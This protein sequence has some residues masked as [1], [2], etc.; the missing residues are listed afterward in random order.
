MTTPIPLVASLLS[1]GVAACA[2]SPAQPGA[3]AP[4]PAPGTAL[5]SEWAPLRP[6]IGA[7]SGTGGDAAHPSRGG[8]TMAPD[9]GGTLLVRR[10][11]NDTATAHHEDLTIIYRGPDGGL[12]A[13]YFDN[14]GHAIHYAVA[15]SADGRN[16][17]FLSDAVAGV[18]RFR[19]TYA[20][21]SDDTLSIAFE[22]APPGSTQFQSYLKGDV[23]RARG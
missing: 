15:P 5:G 18:P 4:A 8:F 3:Q 11:T 7:W 22:I 17:V 2:T 6:L 14:E 10:G 20:V 13:S 9:L 19:L 12:Q 16:I 21:V 1:L 23:H